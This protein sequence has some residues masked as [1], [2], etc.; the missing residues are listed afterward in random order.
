MFLVGLKIY[1]LIEYITYVIQTL[2]ME[3]TFPAGSVSV[4]KWET[5]SCAVNLLNVKSERISYLPSKP[6]Q[7]SSAKKFA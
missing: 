4:E 1:N 5:V 2:E 3:R 7:R 6:A